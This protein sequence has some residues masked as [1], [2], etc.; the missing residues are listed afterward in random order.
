[1]V[2]NIHYRWDFIGLSTD[3]KPTAST[4][5]KVVNGST[6]YEADTSKLYVWYDNQWYEKL[7]LG[8]NG[9]AGQANTTYGGNDITNLYT[10]EELA[11]K[12]ASG[13]FSGLHIGDYIT[14]TVKVG[15]NQERELDFVIAG[16]DYFLGM[17]DTEIVAHHLVMVPDTAF[18]ESMKMNDTSTN[19]GGYYGS[20]AHGIASPAY[21]AGTGGSLTNVVADYEMFL[22]STLEPDDG[23]Y[24]FVRNSSGKWELDSE[25]VGTDLNAYGITYTGTPVEGD[26]IALTFAKGYLEPYRQAIYTAFGEDNILNHREYMSISASTGAWHDARVELMNES[27]VYGQMIRSSNYTSDM[28]A[29]SQLPL[30]Q[31][32]SNRAVALRGKGGSRNGAWLSSTSGSTNFCSVTN[33][34]NAGSNGASTAIAVRPYFLFGKENVLLNTQNRQLENENN[35]LR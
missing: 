25:E 19:T 16:F 21:T 7:A 2:N 5:P 29:K 18:Y 12:V 20:Q 24:T 11:S 17:G 4:S 28:F 6:Y 23:T 27:M 30:F 3:S 10:D 34:G 22:R 14:K 26:T 9:S 33:N 31:M 15:S 32:Q 35:E 8:E 1:M 13:D